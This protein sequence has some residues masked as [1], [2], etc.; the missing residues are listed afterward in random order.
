MQSKRLTPEI[1]L[2]QF[3]EA[4]E[5]LSSVREDIGK[6]EQQ[7]ELVARGE[8]MQKQLNSATTTVESSKYKV[9]QLAATAQAEMQAKR[10]TFSKIYNE[11]MRNTL[12]DC[13]SAS[14]DEGYMPII[15]GGQYTEAMPPC[16][17]TTSLL[18]NDARNELNR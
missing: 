16:L 1:K 18:R 12:K 3:E 10:I 11:M 5:K 13:Q 9:E 14:I 7:R 17:R 4:E 15:N 6:Y 8:A 2:Q